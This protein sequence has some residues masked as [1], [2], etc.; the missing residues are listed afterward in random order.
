M[1]G[2]SAA[3]FVFTILILMIGG[4]V[5]WSLFLRYR[6]RALLHQERIAALEKGMPLPELTDVQPAWS[7]RSYLLKGMMWLFGGIAL[8]VFLGGIAVSTGRTPTVEERVS[9]ARNL[10]FMGATEEEI[11]QVENDTAP[12]DKMPEAMALLGLVPIGV[13]LAYLIYYK[14]ESKHAVPP[15]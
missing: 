7:P 4:V 14:V 12:R 1:R 8:T 5:V 15:R 9:R 3:A 6:K 13:G 11:K 10:K 2:E